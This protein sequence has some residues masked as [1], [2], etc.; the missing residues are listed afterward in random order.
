MPDKQNDK[1]SNIFDY[2]NWRGD[3]G[4]DIVEVCEVDALIFSMLSYIDYDVVVPSE[5][6]GIRKPPA[7]LTVTKRYFQLHSGGDVPSLGLILSRQIFKLLARASKTK[8][9]GLTAPLCHINKISDDDQM[10]FSA[11]AVNTT[12][13]PSIPR[14]RTTAV[15]L[16]LITQTE[17]LRGYLRKP[18]LSF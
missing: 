13:Q 15:S 9:F 11:T 17:I 2:L 6:H 4:F 3:L 18:L 12:S 16:L 8:R 7:L 5:I 14:L 1:F 10:Q